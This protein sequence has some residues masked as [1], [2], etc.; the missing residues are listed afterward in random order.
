[1][2]VLDGAEHLTPRTEIEVR[3]SRSFAG[4]RLLTGDARLACQ[5]EVTGPVSVRKRGVRQADGGVSI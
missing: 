2:E 1:M 3:W 5:A 4:A